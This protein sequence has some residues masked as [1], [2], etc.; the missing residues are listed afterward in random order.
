MPS[1]QSLLGRWLLLSGTTLFSG[2]FLG[3]WLDS[4]LQPAGVERTGL[5]LLA[6]LPGSLI[7]LLGSILE[8]RLLAPLR[9]LQVQLARLAANPD[10]THDFAPEG[11]LRPLRADFERL[12]DGWRQDRQALHC[13][14]EQ[15]ASKALRIR[16]ELEAVLQ[17]LHTPLLLCDQHQRLLLFNPAAEQ[18]FAQSPALG[19]GRRLSELLPLPGLQDALQDLPRDGRARQLLLPWGEHWLRCDLRRVAASQGE[20]LITLQDSTALQTADQRWHAPLARLLPDLRRRSASLVSSSEV[21]ANCQ[22]TPELQGR[23]EAIVREESQA[24]GELV[25]QLARHFDSLQQDS[26][27]LQ[28]TWSNDLWN[29]L[30]ER[31]QRQNIEL[32]AIGIPAWLRADG[33]AL[34]E[35][36]CRLLGQLHEVTGEHRFEAELRLG[37][38]RV[39]LDLIWPG[40]PIDQGRIHCWLQRPLT[41]ASTFPSLL[42]VLRRHDSDCWSLADKDGL[43]ARL[44]LPLPALERVGAPPKARQTRPEFHDFSIAD[45]PPPEAELGARPLGQLEMVVFDTETTGLELRQGDTLVSIGACRIING[46]L[47]AQEAY[48]QFINPGRPIPP[49]ST[50]I[51]GLGDS[52][53]AEA[54]PAAVVLPQFRDFV[55][56][57][58]LVAHNAA[59][60]LLAINLHAEAAGVSFE[61]PVL[62]TLLLSRALDPTL[63]GHG[64][65]A[66]AE[67]FQLS[68][69]PGTRHSALGDARVTAELLLQLLPRLQARGVHS[70]EQALQFQAGGQLERTT[71]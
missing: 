44:R 58:V 17:V 6:L 32:L 18:L 64:L 21:L 16:H 14:A 59:F 10:A 40:Q 47:L 50:L 41:D 20:A 33:P 38:Q 56:H 25:D 54:P 66:L 53:V 13:A 27:L 63:E 46:R 70:L 28:D 3:F 60:D 2:I 22:A 12:R 49:Q 23:L 55:G 37:N 7:L 45:L 67:R 42:D 19:L 52:D 61:M 69:A 62:D 68:F 1:F 5:W 39:Y 26:G 30:S 11:W 71:P 65:D 36:L 15:G 34:L 35:L 29:A 31:I 51:H 9:H 57:A 24:V 43:H 4:T 8:H 48:D